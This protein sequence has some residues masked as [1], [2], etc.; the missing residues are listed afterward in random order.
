[1]K[2]LNKPTLV[3]ARK[4]KSGKFSKITFLC[5]ITLLYVNGNKISQT[6]DHLKKTRVIG[7]MFE[8]KANLPIIKLPAQNNVAHI[9][10][11]YALVFCILLTKSC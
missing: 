6:R 4:N 1:M 8:K 9:S 11:I 2:E 5:L 3:S 10:I 7:G